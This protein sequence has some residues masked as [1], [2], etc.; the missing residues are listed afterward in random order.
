M[1]KHFAAIILMI[2]IATEAFAARQDNIITITGKVVDKANSEPIE[3]V[4]VAIMDKD[5]K[6]IC[7]NTSVADGTFSMQMPGSDAKELDCTLLLSFVG[8]EDINAPLSSFIP[9]KESNH[10]DLGT[11]EMSADKALLEG[12]VVSGKRDLI[13][14]KFDRIVLNVSELAVAKTGTSL[15]VLKNSPGVTVDHE[16]NI[17][18][19]GQTVAVWI[20]G[21]PS[22][23]SGKDLEAYLKG[24]PGNTIE[25]VELISNPSAKYDAEGSG[26]I[27]N[28]K[29]SKGFMKG[30][31]GSLGANFGASFLPVVRFNGNLNANV[32]YKG[33]KTNTA[34]SYTPSY[35][36]TAD[37]SMEEKY[38]GEHL[39]NYSES[40]T[41]T[42]ASYMRHNINLSNDWNISKK[43]ILGVILRA[44]FNGDMNE[45]LP[46]SGL[47]T[48][49]DYG[50][51]GQVQSQEL[52]TAYGQYTKGSNWNANVNYTRTFNE[53]KMQELTLNADYG[54]NVSNVN[55]RQVNILNRDYSM[56]G[57]D[58]G[59]KD[60]TARTL[61]LV[62]FKA[63][64]SQVFW[65]QTGRLETGFKG[66]LSMTRNFFSKYLLDG[67]GGYTGTGTPDQADAT[68]SDK[69]SERNDFQ[70]NEQ[71]YAAYINV[72]KMFSPKWNAQVGL[73]GELTV[74]EGIWTDSPKTGD[75]YFDLFPNAFLS[76]IPSQKAIL[77][78][79]YSY[80]LSRPKYWQLNPF[81]TY[82]NATSYAEGNPLLKPSY[83]HN[84][85]LS[86]IFFGRMNVTAG[87]THNSNF[88]DTQMPILREDGVLVHRY[89]NYGRSQNMFIA[90]SISE[91]P[92]T[93]WWNF[94][95]NLTYFYTQFD[96]Y[97]DKIE[98]MIDTSRRSQNV[99]FGTASTSFFLPKAFKITLDG[100]IATPQIAGFYKTN[101]MGLLNV[102]VEKNFWD[103]KGTLA[104]RATDIL[105][106]M[107]GCISMEENG[108]NIYNLRS[109]TTSTGVNLSFTWRF[110]TSSQS[111][112]RNVGNLEEASRM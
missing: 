56:E 78:L 46:G 45:N 26:G 90:A 34:F 44:N 31:N 104:L 65:K 62:S 32:R 28:I 106:T 73:R 16:G 6:V 47:K 20:D 27:I 71:V 100:W 75:R 35:T 57:G 18:L 80:R 58:F 9:K 39:E 85:N 30:L 96:P 101:L 93:K 23:M 72:A 55:S 40:F 95:V 1:K 109:L 36:G 50:L 67:F 14:H 54:H 79:S 103:G 38:F 81:R 87:Y 105:C 7:G 63:D 52:T 61:D 10:I 21:R 84:I 59:F 42:D 66:A 33:D 29:T 97:K 77:S 4:T 70:Y 19:N 111:T 37:N 53:A 83:S 112:R 2:A 110:G 89:D 22:N 102:G 68:F 98:G 8:Y 17:K 99:F 108:R 48:F 41:S 11:I 92:I 12:A 69:V 24:N 74:T 91:Q 86:A 94:T 25:K 5:G 51:P 49:K 3:Y 43:D 82:I 13:E 60:M 88:S 107:K 15:D 76:Y 64:Y